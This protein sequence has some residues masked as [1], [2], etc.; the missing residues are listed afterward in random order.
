MPATWLA[1]CQRGDSKGRPLLMNLNNALI[2]LENDLFADQLG[3]DDMLQAAV[4]QQSDPRPLTDDDV[5]DIHRWIQRNGLKSIGL[6]TVRQAVEYF[7]RRRRF[8]PVRDYLDALEWDGQKRINVW[9]ITMMGCELS[10]YHQAIGRLFL[11]SMVARIYNPGCQGDYMLIFEGP[12]GTLKSSACRALAEPWFDDNLPDVTNKDSSQYLRGK[13]LIEVSEM[14]AFS[15]VESTHLKAFLSRR[16]E[17]YRPAYGHLE[18]FEP[19]QCVFIGT[20]N[21]DTYLRDD[22]G[23]RRFWPVQC[24]NVALD[25]LFEDRDQLFAEAVHAFKAGDHWWPDR[26]FE[27]TYI[28]PVQT[29]RHEEDIWDDKI[30]E[31]AQ[32]LIEAQRSLGKPHMDVTV[33][34]VASALGIPIHAQDRAC[35]MRIAAS[36]K[37]FG[38]VRCSDG[39]RKF[40]R[41]KTDH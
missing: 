26:E 10:P 24:G 31:K 14:H 32:D 28:Q 23:G 1:Q 8:H 33:A 19:R 40:W 25:R 4:I 18:V 11:I 9:L 37:R 36:L 2:A 6:E 27:R 38:F 21:R 34:Q 16:T 22:T 15:R 13:W 17:R 5:S 30:W 41:L 35:Q 29:S 3:F 12:Q 20:S 7:A 39:S